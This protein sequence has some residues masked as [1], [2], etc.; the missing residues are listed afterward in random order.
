MLAS[1]FFLKKETRKKDRKLTEGSLWLMVCN[2]FILKPELA[3]LC[4]L[5]GILVAMTLIGII[6]Q[7]NTDNLKHDSV[8][9]V[10]MWHT[11]KLIAD[12]LSS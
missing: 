2:I 4:R 3:I 11:R 5:V 9:S 12:I 8:F 1:F 7:C 10:K 6:L